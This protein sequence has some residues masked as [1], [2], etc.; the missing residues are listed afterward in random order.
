[1]LRRIKPCQTFKITNIYFS[2][3][4]EF[5]GSLQYIYFLNIHDNHL[6]LIYID[7]L[8]YTYKLLLVFFT[9]IRI[10]RV[11]H[12]ANGPQIRR[13]AY[14]RL[15]CWSLSKRTKTCNKTFTSWT[16]YQDTYI[17][18][19]IQTRLSELRQFKFQ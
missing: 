2:I 18:I 10:H 19:K 13:N 8:A 5:H 16:S 17:A 1:M 4:K 11:I 6:S 9:M 14:T 3:K 12:K 7:I 15:Y